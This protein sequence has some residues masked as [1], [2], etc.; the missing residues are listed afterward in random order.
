MRPSLA[1]RIVIT[2]FLP[3]I[4]VVG[5]GWITL[6]GVDAGT[7]EPY[8]R[9]VSIFALGVMPI[10]TAYGLVELV[11]IAVPRWRRLRHGNPEG[12]AKL[13]RAA[14]A[15]ALVLAAFQAFGIAKSLEALSGTYAGALYDVGLRSTAVIIASLVAGLCVTF[16]V[17]EIITR[18]GIANGL[19][20]LVVVSEINSARVSVIG[21]IA[22]R[23][24]LQDLAPAAVLGGVVVIAVAIVASW[25]ALRGGSEDACA[26]EDASTS[27]ERGYRDAARALAVTPWIP[28]PASAVAPIPIAASLLLMPATLALFFH[29]EEP[30]SPDRGWV[31]YLATLALTFALSLVLARVI[32]SPREMADVATRLGAGSKEELERAARAAL[33]RALPGT[34]LFLGTLVIADAAGVALPLAGVP[35]VLLPLVTAVVMD[36]ARAVRSE[37]DL[38]SVWTERRI[39]V[40]PVLRAVLEA[41]GIHVRTRG[42]ALLSLLQLFGP[43]AAVDILVREAD[44]PRAS[45]LLRHLLLGEEAPA[46]EPSAAPAPSTSVPTLSRKQRTIGLVV[47]AAIASGILALSTLRPRESSTSANTG[48]RPNLEI[49]TVSD[50]G[51][52]PFENVRDS[53]VPDKI[54]LR[55]EMVPIGL[56]RYGQKETTKRQYAASKADA[57]EPLDAVARRLEG[58]LATLPVPEGTRFAL[59]AT[60]DYDPDTGKA[61]V[62]GYRSMLVAAEP[63]LRTEDVEDAAAM[64]DT[65]GAFEAVYVAVTLSPSGARRFEAVTAANVNRR[66]AILIDGKVTS[67]PVIRS[68]IAGGHVSITMGAGDFEQQRRVAQSLAKGLSGR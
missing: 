38:V 26:R 61:T 27:P 17:A 44:A 33:R 36:A 64:L 60:E 13:E 46:R 57:G 20:M 42:D 37:A 12:R 55:I 50:D 31:W 48:P 25:L 8:G 45:E 67:A 65:Q 21:S 39:S 24:K 9:N 18:Q 23:L 53:N 19:V 41:E 43:Y 68:K 32:H 56:D 52:D 1:R 62:D 66:L 5:G 4:L 3:V 16:I 49:V 54:D 47:T 40:V 2:L 6:P 22:A 15:V 28:I 14:R 59:E 34:L 11:A 10:L 7:V 30:W 63:V 29:V 35:I 58:W 51:P